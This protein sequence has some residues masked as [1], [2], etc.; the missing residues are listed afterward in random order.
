MERTTFV[1]FCDL[2]SEFFYERKHPQAC[3][4]AYMPR[5]TYIKLTLNTRDGIEPFRIL[6]SRKKKLKQRR[7]GD[8]SVTSPNSAL[9]SR[10]RRLSGDCEMWTAVGWGEKRVLGV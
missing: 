9:P 7:T 4:V 2:H 5:D 8:G 1:G 6:E 10:N 3:T